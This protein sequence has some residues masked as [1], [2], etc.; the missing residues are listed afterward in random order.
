MPES[1]GT[2]FPPGTA[3]GVG[4]WP[5]SDVAEAL[6]V[7]RGE[8]P[9]LPHL[10][11]LPERGPGADLVGRAAA[12][13]VAM[14]VDLQPAGWR[15][16]DRPGRDQARADAFW[17]EDLDRMAHVFD[18]WE[19]PL[20]I[21]LAGPWTLAASVWLPRGERAVVD[22]GAAR[23]LVESG[24]EAL[25]ALVR[26]VARLVPGARMVAQVDEPSLPAVLEGRLPTASGFGRLR[27]VEPSVV[28]EGLAAVL[29]AAA[30]AGATTVVHCCASRAPVGLL[31]RTGADGL[32]L[33]TSLLG[34][35][36][37]ESVAAAV[38]DGVRLW[39]GAVPTSGPLPS[40]AD[41]SASLT[42]SWLDLGLPVAGLADV[43]V[44][45]SCGLSGGA[46]DQ[47]RSALARAVETGRALR[48]RA[49]A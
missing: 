18:G 36:A 34:P 28:A 19:G 43:V 39:A 22:P 15:L 33:D 25:A 21:Q 42:R 45:P 8:L 5:G 10:P 17:R 27:A 12:R 13:L 7:V 14:P 11:E 49:A 37:W 20:K 41:A 2:S 29:A 32:S 44:T 16:V 26:D 35:Q 1:A 6:R 46:P 40:A 4:G 38:E 30:G 48:E 3:T 24:A 9:D 31:A 47:A 23:D